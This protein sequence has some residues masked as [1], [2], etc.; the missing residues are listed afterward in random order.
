MVLALALGGC[1]GG[2]TTTGD[3][4]G[5]ASSSSSAGA[6]R[7]AD[8]ATTTTVARRSPSQTLLDRVCD[9]AASVSDAGVVSDPAITEASGVV[10]SRARPDLWWLHN[11]SDDS[12]RIY[13]VEDSGQLLAT[14]D[15]DGAAA[16]DWEDIAIG[17]G[18]APGD[19]DVIYI[20]DIG[21]N[22]L[23]RN[24]PGSAHDTIRVIRLSEPEVATDVSAGPLSTEVTAETLTFVY[25]DGPHDAEALMVD[26]ITGDL[27]IVTKDWAR[28][29]V[30][31]VYRASADQAAGT[32]ATLEQVATVGF[33]MATLVTAADVS[34][35]GAVVALRSYARVDLYP[36]P[37]GMPL[38]AAF[39]Q[40]PCTG[41]TPD[42]FQGEAIGF[43]ADGASYLTLAEGARPVLHR[44]TG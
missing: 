19:P 7:S 31:R 39:D 36:R 18:A 22:A 28:T 13:A 26:P 41:P 5:N 29:G 21:D 34:P 12:A 33:D 20:G 43:T 23:Y 9:G 17:P 40:E 11:D 44:T 14:V 8:D 6:D 30:S 1:S 10:A 25:P 37:A 32:T 38:W 4:S 2:D 3:G 15:L 27:L 24:D 35:D 16:R 42:E